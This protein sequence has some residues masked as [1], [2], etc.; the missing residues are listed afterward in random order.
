MREG[1]LD[2]GD[3]DALF[4]RMRISLLIRDEPVRF[5]A[6][7]AQSRVAPWSAKD[8]VGGKPPRRFL[9]HGERA[10]AFLVATIPNFDQVRWSLATS[11]K[12]TR[13]PEL[14][15][16]ELAISQ[17]EAEQLFAS[18]RFSVAAYQ[19]KT[20]P[21]SGNNSPALQRTPGS[22]SA[23]MAA[24]H[25]GTRA[26]NMSRPPKVSSMAGRAFYSAQ[27]PEHPTGELAVAKLDTG[28]W[29]CVYPFAV[30][31]PVDGDHSGVHTDT[32]VMLEIRTTCLKAANTP[33]SPR[34]W[35][36]TAS[37]VID[38][39]TA[40]LE[41]LASRLSS[42][43]LEHGKDLRSTHG[44]LFEAEMDG[45]S[46]EATATEPVIAR[47]T[48]QILVSTRPIVDIDTRVVNLPVGFGT[49]AALVEVSVYCDPA[50]TCAGELVLN[51]VQLQSLDWHAQLLAPVDLPLPFTMTPGSCWVSVFRVNALSRATSDTV[52]SRLKLLN[53][54]NPLNPGALA[55]ELADHC[56]GLSARVVI[57]SQ[58]ASLLELTRHISVPAEQTPAPVASTLSDGTTYIHS[59]A[60]AD[61][62]SNVNTPA[63]SFPSTR[64]GRSSDAFTHHPQFAMET[65]RATKGG[66]IAAGASGHTKTASL[67]ITMHSQHL[68]LRKHSL[69]HVSGKPHLVDSTLFHAGERLGRPVGKNAPL[70]LH[71]RSNLLAQRSRAVTLNA[72][73]QVHCSQSPVSVIQSV[74]S[75]SHPASSGR[76]SSETDQ[77]SLRRRRSSVQAAIGPEPHHQAAE[78]RTTIG[79]IDIAFDAPPKA[80]LGDEVSVRVHLT[81]NTSAHFTRLCLVDD[82]VAAETDDATLE[83]AVSMRGLLPKEYATTV[84]PLQ[85]GGSTFVVLKF[86]AAAPQ[87]H[88]I[89][90]LRLVDLSANSDNKIIAVVKV[91][92]VIY[93]D[94]CE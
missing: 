34:V 38:D 51:S 20:V 49:D 60:D 59:D 76:Y 15:R 70:G 50:A 87:F 65:L 72:T 13:A 57:G 42:E 22:D 73:G 33:N 5:A 37:D 47:R 6:E 56:A 14:A 11:M 68:P 48:V 40:Q 77:E 66:G 45:L 53:T 82:P 3:I 79:T 10:Q 83:G 35:L 74:A 2:A 75:S 89:G 43:M 84:P 29:C 28:A 27:V 61:V 85:P 26:T 52:L 44:T 21:A 19:A 64:S 78:A 16:G 25:D 58:E 69:A 62:A 41:D 46:L 4:K 92:F 7:P 17:S 8:V 91:P 90:S 18:L 93:V 1:L 80:E 9:Y 36:E 55:T 67:D 12:R 94:E 23:Q 24:L 71:D 30:N 81:N 54:R 88:T 31:V 32:A 86:M 39:R 63:A